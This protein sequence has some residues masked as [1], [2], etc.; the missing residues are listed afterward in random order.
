MQHVP[1]SKILHMQHPYTMVPLLKDTLE[2]MSL[3][4]DRIIGSKYYECL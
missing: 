3:I 1:E 2:G 4:K